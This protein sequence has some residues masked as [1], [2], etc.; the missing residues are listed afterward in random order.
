LQYQDLLTQ[1]NV[2]KKQ[3]VFGTPKVLEV[4]E[5][6]VLHGV[7]IGIKGGGLT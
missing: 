3:I 2:F 5:N 6:E 4:V 7:V 1:G